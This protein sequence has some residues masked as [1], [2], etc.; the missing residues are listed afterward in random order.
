MGLIPKKKYAQSTSSLDKLVDLLVELQTEEENNKSTNF[1]EIN[2]EK[3]SLIEKEKT[4]AII[5]LD[6]PPNNS[7]NPEINF[8][9]KINHQ[10]TEKKIKLEN[11]PV[12]STVFVDSID[13]F[14]VKKI[15]KKLEKRI[16]TLEDKIYQPTDLINPI[17]PLIKELLTSK[18]TYA[19]EVLLDATVP[20]I[21]KI[22][23]QKA[24]QNS[25][26][27][28]DALADILPG[29]ITEET[30]RIPQAIAKA[31]A[32]EIAIAIQEQIRLDRDSI[33]NTLGPEMGKAIKTQI[34]LEK[35]AMV[36]ALYPVIGN[37]I[38]RYMAEV[39][40]QINQKVEHT[41]STEG[42][43][44]KIKAKIQGVSEAELIFQESIRFAVQAIFLIHKTSG[45]VIRE[46][47]TT[48]EHKLD[49]NMVA[50]MLTAIRSFAN[51]C[52]SQSEEVS[53][54]NEIEYSDS[55][56]I[57]EVAGYCYL[58]IVV[59]GE[60]PARFIQKARD[61]LGKIVLNYDKYIEE[62]EGDP[63]TIPPPVQILLESLIE[64]EAKQTKEAKTKP[65]ITLF[66]LLLIIL[67]CF[68]FPI[69]RSRVA[70]NLEQKV[71]KALD[72]APELSVYRLTPKIKHQKIT[73]TGR[74]PNNYLREKATQ[75]TRSTVP[76]FDIN[77]QI[78]AVD[79]PPDPTLTREEVARTIKI[80]NQRK[81]VGIFG[82]YLGDTV[83]VTGIVIG[84]RQAEEITQGF[85]QIPGVKSVISTLQTNVPTLSIR[86][87]FHLNSDRVQAQDITGKIK[88]IKEF[89]QQ[90]P[91]VKLKIIGN[92]S[93][94]ENV[95]DKP[96][97][98]LK[99]AK[100]VEKALIDQG[101]NS[102]RLKS[103]A[104]TKLPPNVTQKQPSWL[105]RCVWF[106][107]FL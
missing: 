14:Q 60:T 51:D 84:D 22:I 26:E 6:D 91:A 107:T 74:V 77:N 101:I 71:L 98:A 104:S 99:R 83:K 92:S 72:A 94:F 20:I 18:V 25:Q 90:H 67:S 103:S 76:N 33:S 69:Y 52:I 54:L 1:S 64:T 82:K 3:L 44:R 89:L 100:S 41:L 7:T 106:E 8:T 2:T 56:I 93:A 39:I 5:L 73:L 12:V 46:V 45:L 13:D 57:L 75:I 15:I 63:E 102:K 32:P 86:V 43:K 23:K 78:I 68:S 81:E 10:P 66:I 61:T 34:T 65:P 16:K 58:A 28:S 30:K 9:K 50:G 62:F 11:N 31:M 87:Y 40:N 96:E 48:T 95:K 38:S 97:L 79:I 21:D 70:H 27:M 47:Q 42:I 49:S 53:E 29:A 88:S 105:S 24:L 4:A 85:K 59:K 17:L 37:T 80:F 35:D 36:D 55:R 19:R